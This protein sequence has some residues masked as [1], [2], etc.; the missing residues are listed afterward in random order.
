M[1]DNLD[2]KILEILQKDNLT[3]Q[4]EIGDKIGLSAPAV[5]RRIKKLRDEGIIEKDISI[6]D[7][8]KIGSNVTV[9]VEIFLE[10]KKIEEID[11]LKKEFSCVPEIQQCFHITGESDFFLVMV[12]PSMTYYESITRTLF[13]GNENIKRFR[14]SVVMGISKNSLEIP[15]NVSL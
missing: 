1:I 10:R 2:Y 8:D 11:L 5:Q 13:F 6:I 9:L 14:T 15:L 7:R 4:R 3:P 12:V